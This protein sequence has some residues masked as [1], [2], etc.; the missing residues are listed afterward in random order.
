[1]FIEINLY[2]YND[3]EGIKCYRAECGSKE[4][5]GNTSNTPHV[6]LPVTRRY[7]IV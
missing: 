6:L 5:I 4:E 7:Q 1:M 2:S 3:A